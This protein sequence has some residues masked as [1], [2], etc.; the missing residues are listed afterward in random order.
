VAALRL[1]AKGRGGGGVTGEGGRGGECAGQGVGLFATDAR[2]GH[3]QQQTARFRGVCQCVEV[4][5][6]AA[7]TSCV[8][9]TAHIYSQSTGVS[10]CR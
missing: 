6:E 5:G 1:A 8:Q 2:T 7:V 4:A 10:K 9:L 3:K